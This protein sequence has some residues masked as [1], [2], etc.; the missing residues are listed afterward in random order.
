MTEVDPRERVLR[1]LTADDEDLRRLAFERRTAGFRG[2]PGGFP[3]EG[4]A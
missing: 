2:E 4:P 1:D 3:G